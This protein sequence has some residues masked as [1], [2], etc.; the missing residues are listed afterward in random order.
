LPKL[1]VKRFGAHLKEIT[2][3]L[4]NYLKA[5]MIMVFI[6][7]IIVLAGLYIFKFAGMNV[8][9]PLLAALGIGFVDALPILGSGSVMIPWAII[10]AM[11]GDMKL[12]IR[13]FYIIINY[14][15]GK[16]VY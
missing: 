15:G 10:S 11:N 13:A 6:S 3:A 4:G 8:A 7:F 9:Y 14:N 5:E 2:S 16:A 1:W 12:A